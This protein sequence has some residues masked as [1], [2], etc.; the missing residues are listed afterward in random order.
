[1]NQEIKRVANTVTEQPTEITITRKPKDLLD[2][3]LIFLKVRSLKGKILIEVPKLGLLYQ[4]TALYTEIHI[5]EKKDKLIDWGNDLLVSNIPKMAEIVATYIN[6]K[7]NEKPP[8]N[9]TNYILDNMDVEDLYLVTNIIKSYMDIAPFIHSISLI[10]SLDLIS[11]SLMEESL[12]NT[13]E[14]IAPGDLSDQL[15]NTL[16]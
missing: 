7:R 10:R 15:V 11:P 14:I 9:L 16:G 4:L 6:N 5:P 8:E 12:P 3:I 13:G 2:R 1:M